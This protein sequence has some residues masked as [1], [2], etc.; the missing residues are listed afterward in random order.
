MKILIT[1][2]AGFIGAN[3]VEYFLEKNND[4]LLINLDKLTYAG[5]LANL[6]E[7]DDNPNYRFVKGDICDR[8]LLDELFKKY[9]FYIKALF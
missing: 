2:G 7:V 1:G 9:D 5:D 8:E 4:T 3:F 6:K